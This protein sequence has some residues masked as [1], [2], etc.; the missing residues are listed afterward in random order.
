MTDSRFAFDPNTITRPNQNYFGFPY[1]IQESALVFVPVPWDVTTS[2]GSGAA[3]GPQAILDASPQLDFYDFDVPHAWELGYGTVPINADIRAQNNA[4]RAIAQ[5]VI[6]HLE[7][8]GDPTDAAIQN[9]LATVNTA[10]VALNTWVREQ[11]Q[12]LLEQGKW[13][14]VVGGDH[15]AP[16]G[17]MEAIGDFAGPYGI[18]HID[19]HMDLR[20][21]YEGFTYSHASIMDHALHI[22]QV[23]QLVQVGVRDVCPEEVDRAQGD[24]RVRFFSDPQL[25]ANAY[26][27]MSWGHQCA[28]I[29]S[30]LPE[31]VYVSFD[32][33][34]LNPLFCPHTGTPVPGGL[35][36]SEAVFLIRCLAQ[37][38]RKI[39]GFDLCEVAPG[40]NDEWDGNVG[41]RLLYKLANLMVLSQR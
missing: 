6:H 20:R 28:E 38:G 37:S 30:L 39:I 15:S 34:G 25:K 9:A 13:V 29:I 23:T 3:E 26:D 8:G 10:C 35:D 31:Q 4:I 11:S 18:L 24:R 21:A 33:D 17:L 19:A 27:G 14:G 2:Y 5:T 1:A 7:G 32:I 22:P 36:F 12:T 41:A 40:P 16:L